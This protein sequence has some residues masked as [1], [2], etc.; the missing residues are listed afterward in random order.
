MSV[1]NENQRKNI[2]RKISQLVSETRASLALTKPQLDAAIA[3]A[4]QWIDDNASSYNNALPAEAK[5][6]LSANQKVLLFFLVANER[7]DIL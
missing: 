5:A 2:R 6:N 7:F 4:D 3:A 1:L